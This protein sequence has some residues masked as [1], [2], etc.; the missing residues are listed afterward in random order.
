MVTSDDTGEETAESLFTSTGTE[1]YELVEV[2]P[3]DI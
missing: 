2:C 1:L 3:G